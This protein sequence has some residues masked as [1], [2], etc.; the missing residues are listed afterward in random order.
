MLEKLEKLPEA[1]E[2]FSACADIPGGV[3]IFF[4]EKGD[5]FIETETIA[6]SICAGCIVRTECGNFALRHRIKYGVW[7]GLSWDDRETIL[8][9]NVATQE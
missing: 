9:S 7:G 1:W 4:P 3:D 6:K 2:E 5:N 8:K